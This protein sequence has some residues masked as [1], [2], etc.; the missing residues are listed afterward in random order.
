MKTRLDTAI[1]M[2]L[3]TIVDFVDG[4]APHT[5]LT[6]EHAHTASVNVQAA[7]QH[8]PVLEQRW[9]TAR[10]EATE[11]WTNASSLWAAA[12]EQLSPE[13]DEQHPLIRLEHAMIARKRKVMIF[14]DRIDQLLRTLAHNEEDWGLRST[15]QTE[16]RILVIGSCNTVPAEA[17]TY[18][19]AFYQFFNER[20]TA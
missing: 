3:E 17:L 1:E 16:Q 10:V 15:L 11:A 8:R 19:R 5:I 7:M 4:G 9:M 20:A 2:T 13:D 18:E 12:A 6:G 14:T